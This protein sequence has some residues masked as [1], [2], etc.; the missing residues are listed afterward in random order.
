M[1]GR[2]IV[3]M[4][5]LADVIADVRDEHCA[6]MVYPMLEP[7]A[8]LVVAG[9]AGTVACEGSVSRRLGRLAATLD[10]LDVAEGHLRDAIALEDAMGAAP[11]AATSRMY[12]S[13]VLHV[14]GGGQTLAAG[15]SARSALAAMQSIGMPG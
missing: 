14:R 4:S 6:E 3:T 11:F 10:R 5:M 12:L 13:S 2:W 1:D 9:G 7:F 15:Q 8:G